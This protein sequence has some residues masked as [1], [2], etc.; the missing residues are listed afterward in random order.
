MEEKEF[1]A[2]DSAG[3]DTLEEVVTTDCVIFHEAPCERP[4]LVDSLTV[5]DLSVQ[6]QLRINKRLRS[7]FLF[8]SRREFTER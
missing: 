3:E 4:P 2:T 1:T 6:F 5:K 8:I 7:Q